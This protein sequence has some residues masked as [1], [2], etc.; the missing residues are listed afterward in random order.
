MVGFIVTKAG[1]N[2][3]R[4]HLPSEYGC[5]NGVKPSSPAPCRH[6]SDPTI[7]SLR[8]QGCRPVLAEYLS[9]GLLPWGRCNFSGCR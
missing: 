3:A 1:T 6:V 9:R 5:A 2:T 8:G 7:A 4:N